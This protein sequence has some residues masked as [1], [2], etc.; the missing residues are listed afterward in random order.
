MGLYKELTPIPPQTHR[1]HC[2]VKVTQWPDRGQT[3]ANWI[4]QS[5]VTPQAHRDRWIPVRK[6]AALPP[7]ASP[8]VREGETLKPGRLGRERG[9]RERH[10]RQ[11]L[12]NL[13][14]WTHT[15]F[16]ELKFRTCYLKI[17]MGQS[18]QGTHGEQGNIAQMLLMEV[19]TSPKEG[20]GL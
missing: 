19:K 18:H 17:S 7:G 1:C 10:W 13:P 3:E 11:V 8:R 20:A 14:K 2:L 12:V 9:S 6:T 16:S 4:N 5:P 15:E